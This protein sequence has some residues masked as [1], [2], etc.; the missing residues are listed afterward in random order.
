MNFSRFLLVAGLFFAIASTISCSSEDGQ[1]GKDGKDGTNCVVEPNAASGFDVICDG[2]K[3]GELFNGKDAECISEPH[4]DSLLII[5]NGQLIGVLGNG[6][7]GADGKNGTNGEAGANGETGAS[8][9]ASEDGAYFVMICGEEEKARWPK[10]MC[11]STAYDPAKE[12]CD[13]RDGKTYRYVKIG[14]QYWL[15]ENMNYN[16]NNKK[17]NWDAAKTACPTSWHLPSND[18]WGTLTSFIGS[19]PGTKLKATSG[20]A[21]HATY[22]NGT[23]N[24]GFSALPDDG[25]NS[26]NWWTSSEASPTTV[27]NYRE[28]TYNSGN[29]T[30]NLEDKTALKSVRCVRN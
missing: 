2:T 18:E 24:Y 19:N 20:W 6:K 5:C 27:A 16:A 29:L 13:Y 25:S 28:I 8:C 10:A 3:M 14:E 9:D 7:N 12:A 4:A 1:D 22:G 17:Y 26:G 30:N 11:G 21:D 15:A 23:D